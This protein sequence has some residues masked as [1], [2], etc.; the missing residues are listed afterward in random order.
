MTQPIRVGVLLLEKRSHKWLL[1]VLW[2]VFMFFWEDVVFTEKGR[3]GPVKWPK[4]A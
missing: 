1:L 3:V 2:S 4:F